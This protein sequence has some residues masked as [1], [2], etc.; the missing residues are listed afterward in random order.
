LKVC[1]VSHWVPS[2]RCG[3]K[4][5]SYSLARALAEA[6]VEVVG[7]NHERLI[8]PSREYFRWLAGKANQTGA[9]LTHIQYDFG[10][11]RHPINWW[12]PIDE[13]F[14]TRVKKPLVATLHSTGG[15]GDD[16][17]AKHAQAL[18]VHNKPMFDQLRA[19]KDKAWIIPHGCPEGPPYG[20]MEAREKLQLPLDVKL[21]VVHGFITPAKGHDLALEAYRKLKLP[22]ARMV[23]AGG[24]HIDAETDYI[25]TVKEKA[26]ELGVPVTGYLDD[27]TSDL[28]L[29]AADVV[30]HPARMASE[31]GVVARALGYWKCVVA[32]DHP[33]FRDKP[34]A[35]ARDLD[36][37]VDLLRE[38]LTDDLTRVKFERKA[39]EYAAMWSWRKVARYHRSLYKMVAEGRSYD[40][41]LQAV[42]DVAWQA[43][44][45]GATGRLEVEAN[46][47]QRVRLEWVRMRTH[48]RCLD[49]GCSFGYTLKSGVGVDISLPRLLFGKYLYGDRM[50]FVL[51]DGA[52]LPFREDVFDTVLLD[53]VLEHVPDP[54]ALLREARRVGRRVVATVPNEAACP[55]RSPEHIHQFTRVNFEETF[56]KAGFSNIIV[57]GL[58][59]SQ[60]A[61]WCGVASK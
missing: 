31:S 53:E 14:L 36:G 25:R 39:R 23:F 16:V 27:E 43:W 49:V 37:M 21:I 34:V 58:R 7:V 51:A 24:W 15:P 42:K 4:S 61:W 11:W 33:A 12:E 48:G 38:L 52:R 28:W 6:G 8:P 10:R 5:Y 30:L 22:G 46:P 18:I 17:V 47:E 44:L 32:S 59:A 13:E 9:D 1:M 55:Y 45:V 26:K 60:M 3:I 50:D 41:E 56:K 2:Y 20:R 57:E 35:R 54:V 40:P 29:C 19:G